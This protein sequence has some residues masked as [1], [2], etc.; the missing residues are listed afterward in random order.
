MDVHKKDVVARVV[1][2]NRKD[3]RTFETM[4]TDLLVLAD[5]WV[6]RMGV[7]GVPGLSIRTITRGIGQMSD[8]AQSFQRK[9]L[10]QSVQLV[11]RAW[12]SDKQ[13]FLVEHLLKGWDEV[14]RG[15][16]R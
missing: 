4:T 10:Q 5:W 12:P 16:A 11:P 8:D 2:D 9:G 7:D 3:I 6:D 14:L 1:T 13:R 15:P